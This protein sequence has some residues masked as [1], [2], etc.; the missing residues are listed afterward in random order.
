[1]PNYFVKTCFF[2]E[3]TGKNQDLRKNYYYYYYYYYYH[4]RRRHTLSS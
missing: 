1:M 3:V 4:R 2:Q